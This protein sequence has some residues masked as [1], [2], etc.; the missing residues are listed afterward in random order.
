MVGCMNRKDTL[1]LAEP[2]GNIEGP[3]T[4]LKNN[5][6][7]LGLHYLMFD[8]QYFQYTFCTALFCSVSALVRTK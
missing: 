2:F 6:T 5:L 4:A 8:N 7:Q 3:K 1:N